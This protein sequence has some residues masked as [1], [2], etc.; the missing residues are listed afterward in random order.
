MQ[1]PLSTAVVTTLLQNLAQNNKQD[2]VVEN[3]FYIGIIFN[4]GATTCAV[5]CLFILSDFMSKAHIIAATD[6]HSLPRRLLSNDRTSYGY[7]LEYSERE[8]LREF[9]LRRSWSVAKAVMIH[10]FILGTVC[11]FFGMGFWVWRQ[12][13]TQVAVVVTIFLSLVGGAS[14]FVLLLLVTGK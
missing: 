9:G 7:F 5:L 3:F 6:I 8:V 13:V 4:L 10:C 2:T 1:S 11:T 12:C 14:G